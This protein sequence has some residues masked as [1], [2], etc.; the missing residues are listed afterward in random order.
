MVLI[1][2]EHRNIMSAINR[3]VRISNYSEILPSWANVFY[4]VWMLDLAQ[5]TYTW[6]FTN[7]NLISGDVPSQGP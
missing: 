5:G 6:S 3:R 7:Q 4:L 2:W 1:C